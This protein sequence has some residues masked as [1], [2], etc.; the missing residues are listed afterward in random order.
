MRPLHPRN[1]HDPRGQRCKHDAAH[2]GVRASK[3]PSVAGAS[4]PEESPCAETGFAR[5]VRAPS[6]SPQRLIVRRAEWIVSAVGSHRDPRPYAR[7][8]GS[9]ALQLCALKPPQP[10]IIRRANWGFCDF[11]YRGP[12]E[13]RQAQPLGRCSC[14]Q[15]GWVRLNGRL[16]PGN[17]F[18][19]NLP[20]SVSPNTKERA[21]EL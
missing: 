19:A 18:Q 8:G 9:K 15:V 6:R 4:L 1:E 10:L 21:N 13:A 12:A 14:G 17:S 7:P 20:E 16:K 2:T 3:L 11:P 5:R